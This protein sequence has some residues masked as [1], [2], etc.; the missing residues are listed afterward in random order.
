MS[1]CPLGQVMAP[2]LEGW[3]IS[4]ALA[5]GSPHCRASNFLTCAKNIAKQPTEKLCHV[6]MADCFLKIKGILASKSR[7]RV[8]AM[9][10]SRVTRLLQV[11]APKVP[12]HAY[13]HAI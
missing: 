11:K 12:T 4:A 3:R 13:K 9:A 10:G 6:G 5:G 8:L 2:R 7:V 1:L